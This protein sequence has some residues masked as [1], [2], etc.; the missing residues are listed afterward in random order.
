M[1]HLRMLPLREVSRF[2]NP[3][4]LARV[5]RPIRTNVS[6][7]LYHYDKLTG[8]LGDLIGDA[9]GVRG[10]GSNSIGDVT[11]VVADLSNFRGDVKILRAKAL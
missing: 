11:G 3:E 4:R 1:S 7:D 9:R 5:T 8:D 10:N 6:S 2:R